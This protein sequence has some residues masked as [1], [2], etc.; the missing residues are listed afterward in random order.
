[1]GIF[2]VAA[3]AGFLLFGW[4]ECIQK[5]RSDLQKLRLQRVLGVSGLLAL[6]ILTPCVIILTTQWPSYDVFRIVQ[7]LTG[8]ETAQFILGVVFGCILRYWGPDLWALKIQTWPSH[9]S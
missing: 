5:S 8:R 6:F 1:M 4:I 3:L 9:L 7:Y 2:A